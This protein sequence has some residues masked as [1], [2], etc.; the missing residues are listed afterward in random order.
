[1]SC[2]Y[3]DISSLLKQ[4]L[5]RSVDVGQYKFAG[6]QIAPAI[7]I[8]ANKAKQSP[9][10]GTEVFGLECVIY[11]PEPQ[12]NQYMGA[13]ST[14]DR[15]EIQIRQWDINGTT[16]EA[17]DCAIASSPYPVT[18]TIRV[19]GSGTT[20]QPEIYRLILEVARYVSQYD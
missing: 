20:G 18:S 4:W 14:T 7:T 5:I 6:G 13:V 12:D 16:L 8:V 17:K 10:P 1:M 19:P 11:Y 2:N 3:K 9:P 15:W